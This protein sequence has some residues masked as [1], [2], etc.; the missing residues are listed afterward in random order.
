MLISPDASAEAV[1]EKNRGVLGNNSMKKIK[2]SRT[3]LKVA[4]NIISLGVKP[5]MEKI[6]PFGI[7]EATEKLLVKSGATNATIVKFARS[8]T[9]VFIYE[10][11]DW[12]LPGQFEA[13]AYR[14][15]FYELQVRDGISAGAT[16]ILILGAGYDTMGWRLAPEFA[17][18]KFFEI[19]HPATSCVKKT[20]I[21]L[22]E[23]RNNLY[24]ISEDLAKHKLID[25]LKTNKLWDQ[26][27]KTVIVA[28]GLLM[29]LPGEAVQ[30]LFR[31]CAITTGADSKIAFTY[32]GM[33]VDNLPDAGRWSKL[34]LWSL[35]AI[36]EPWLWS[37][38]PEDLGSFLKET[39]WTNSSKLVGDSNK[40]GVE[41]FGVATI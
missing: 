34:F 36:G 25:V 6:L 24:L 21:E 11:L 10:A 15:A 27:A 23:K 8:K 22:M 1:F 5:G 40:H 37:I 31:Q 30:D 20:G 4:L 29:Y 18:V 12:I 38:R 14:K 41:F 9:A 39:G 2:P 35:K 28:E 19:D 7:V 32:I 16:Q 17:D 33:G 3:A 13:F 26:T